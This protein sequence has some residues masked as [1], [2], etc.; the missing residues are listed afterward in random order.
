MRCLRALVI[1]VVPWSHRFDVG[2]FRV[3]FVWIEQALGHVSP[4]VLGFLLSV[5]FHANLAITLNL[6]ITWK[7]REPLTQQLYFG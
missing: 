7:A 2:I 1:G 3:R 6:R 4:R 5:P